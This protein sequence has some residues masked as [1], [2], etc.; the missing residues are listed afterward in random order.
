R[1]DGDARAQGGADEAAASEPLELVALGE[2]FADALVPLGED[3][4]ELALAE[5]PGGVGLAGEGVPGLAG[6][7]PENRD[8]VDE[9]R[10]QE[11]DVP[12]TVVMHADREHQRVERD[13]PRVVGD[14]ERAALGD[15]ADA[16]E[17]DAE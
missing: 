11:T 2:G 1:D 13:R 17:L 15:V 7:M 4:D 12:S 8:L 6:Q 9:V 3:A 5:Q 10:A 14:E 16:D